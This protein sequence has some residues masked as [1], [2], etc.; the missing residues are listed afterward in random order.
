MW[1]G[2]R[3]AHESN[4]PA[5]ECWS[6]ALENRTKPLGARDVES[7]I[8]V[9]STRPVEIRQLV[10]IA[11]CIVLRMHEAQVFVSLSPFLAPSAGRHL[12]RMR[13][14]GC[15]VKSFALPGVRFFRCLN[16]PSLVQTLAIRR[17]RSAP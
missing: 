6:A 7:R 3:R 2:H 9:T 10:A 8:L 5:I 12:A 14:C 1:L 16:E 15:R 4:L 17:K 11:I 13:I